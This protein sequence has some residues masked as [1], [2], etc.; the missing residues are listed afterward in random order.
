MTDDEIEPSLP[1]EKNEI[2]KWMTTNPSIR[3]KRAREC[4][5]VSMRTRRW[6]CPQHFRISTTI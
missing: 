5:W 6:K 2:E 4:E 3:Q 1:P